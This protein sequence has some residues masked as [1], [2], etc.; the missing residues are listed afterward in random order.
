[1]SVTTAGDPSSAGAGILAGPVGP[2]AA[3]APGPGRCAA[4]RT[5]SVASGAILSPGF[6]I[7]T[8]LPNRRTDVD[9]RKR[10]AAAYNG[11][12]RL[13]ETAEQVNSGPARR[14]LRTRGSDRVPERLLHFARERERSLRRGAGHAARHPVARH[15]AVESAFSRQFEVHAEARHAHALEGQG[16]VADAEPAGPLGA[17]LSEIHVDGNL[18]AVPQHEAVPPLR[19]GA[20]GLRPCADAGAADCDR[21]QSE[22]HPFAHGDLLGAAVRL[23]H[24]DLHLARAIPAGINNPP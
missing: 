11:A 3:W 5:T 17:R 6:P 20:A 21:D 12:G 10:R 13:Q 23:A 24:P 15:R 14:S 16:T 4:V 19:N 22:Q 9:S 18:Q 8:C 2:A 7:E 1:M